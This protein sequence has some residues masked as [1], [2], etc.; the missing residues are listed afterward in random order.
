LSSADDSSRVRELE[1]TLQNE[2]NVYQKNLTLYK[3]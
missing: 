3:D 1:Q 2:K